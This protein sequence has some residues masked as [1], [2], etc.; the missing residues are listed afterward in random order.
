MNEV[1]FKIKLEEND[2]ITYHRSS[3]FASFTK[4]LA[5]VFMLALFCFM[6]YY[7][8]T[9]NTHF[10]LMVVSSLPT[11]SYIA[12]FVHYI[13]LNAKTEFAH[14]SFKDFEPLFT[15][16]EDRF[17]IERKNGN[18]SRIMLMDLLCVWETRKYFYFFV[19]KNNTIIVP[20]RFISSQDLAF[21]KKV[22]SELPRKKR[23]TPFKLSFG[24]I[25]GSIAVFLFLTFVVT[26]FIIS[27]KM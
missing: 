20:K 23:K 24:Q 11:V 14:S 13:P 15:L 4:N 27:F 3:L 17:S 21:C 2:Y 16:S 12:L 1:K 9:T 18:T 26:M 19:S 25:I 22:I 5:M 7:Y 6:V 10:W 8:K